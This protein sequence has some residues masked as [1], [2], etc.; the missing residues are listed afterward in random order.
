MCFVFV[1]RKKDNSRNTHFM[2]VV[3]KMIKAIKIKFDIHIYRLVHIVSHSDH[4]T[5][6]QFVLIHANVLDINAY[7]NAMRNIFSSSKLGVQVGV[8]I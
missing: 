1:G 7:M 5:V 6:R 3:G 4:V 8:T 2:L